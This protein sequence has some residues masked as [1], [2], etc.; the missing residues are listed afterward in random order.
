MSPF[1]PL[2]GTHLVITTVFVSIFMYL[3]TC[4]HALFCFIENYSGIGFYYPAM[5]TVKGSIVPEGQR[6]AIYN[7]FRFPLNLF[8]LTFLVGNYSTETSFTANA[9]LLMMACM[10]QIHLV[11]LG[12]K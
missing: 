6:A 1:L 11:R 4:L 10:L 7:V 2:Q 5:G 8:M 9:V 12:G 3:L